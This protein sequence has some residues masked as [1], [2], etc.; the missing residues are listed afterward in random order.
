[1]NE[2]DYC[3]ECSIFMLFSY[4]EVYILV[5]LINN[6]LHTC[7]NGDIE[8]IKSSLSSAAVHDAS[9]STLLEIEVTI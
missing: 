9:L 6:S 2:L 5:F 3:S 1:M 7:S 8:A 4:I